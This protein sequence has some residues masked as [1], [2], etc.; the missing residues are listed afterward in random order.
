MFSPYFDAPVLATANHLPE[1]VAKY[2]IAILQA[3]SFLGRAT[4]GFL[5]DR[6]GAWRVFVSMGLLTAIVLF[7]FWTAPVNAAATVAGMACYGY[8][9]GAWIT[10]VSAVTVAIS[11]PHE[12]GMRVGMMWTVVSIPILAGPVVCGGECKHLK[13]RTQLTVQCW[14]RPTEDVSQLPVSSAVYLTWLERLSASCL[15]WFVWCGH[16]R[17]TTLTR[18]ASE[19]DDGLEA[20]CNKTIWPPAYVIY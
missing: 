3:G 16:G 4:S 19:M 1:S 13:R 6:L 9:S 2:S 5:A 12:A 7:S 11:A 10:L 17:P 8:T 14:S 18:F 20:M 15:F